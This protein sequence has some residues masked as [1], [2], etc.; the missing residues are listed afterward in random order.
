MKKAVKIILIVIPIILVIGASTILG[1]LLYTK[2]NIGY[3]IGESTITGYIYPSIIETFFGFIIVETP[4]TI[5]NSGLYPIR[6][7]TI[8]LTVIGT[9]F[10]VEFLNGLVLGTGTN[11]LG[12][13]LVGEQWSGTLVLNMTQNIVALA[14]NDGYMEVHVDIS[15]KLD[16]GIFKISNQQTDIQTKTWP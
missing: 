1:T 15:L 9:D 2:N 6:D 5:N 3:D 16:L 14:L 8:V 7:L 4:I 12:D 11:Y 13:I 10:P